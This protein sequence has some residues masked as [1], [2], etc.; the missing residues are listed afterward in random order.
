MRK[1]RVMTVVAMVCMF[2]LMLSGCNGIGGGMGGGGNA[3]APYD[4]TIDEV[5]TCGTYDGDVLVANLSVENKSKDYVPAS[6]IA[7]DITAT[8]DGEPLNSS[9]LSSMDEN[10]VNVEGN[11]EPGGSGKS[12]AVYAIGDKTEGEVVLT[13][14]TY[15]E[16][17]K[18][19]EFMK[20]TINL[21]DVEKRIEESDFAITID[22]VLKTDNEEHKDIVV[23]D[24]TFTNNS[25]EAT[26]Y[27]GALDFKVFQKG[28][29]LQRGYLPY[30]HPAYDEELD[31]NS[32]REI[33]GGSDL[34][35]RAVYEL[36]DPNAPIEVKAVDYWKN[37][38]E[39]VLE[40]EIKLEEGDGGDDSIVA[41]SV[42]TA[43]KFTFTVDDAIIGLSKY[44]ETPI[45][46]LAGTFTNNSD[47]AI[48]FSW[49]LGTKAV[50][51]GYT[52]P[53]AYLSGSNNFNYNEIEPG[54]TIPIFIGWEI[55]DSEGD[56]TLTVVDNEH[57]AKEEIYSKTFTI[58]ELMENTESYQ[59]T[60][61]VIDGSL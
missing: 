33:Q 46:V 59:E 36:N 48:S 35:V 17:G 20:E 28:T 34:A 56:I 55:A 61:E 15:G 30:K 11:I 51:E 26:S 2:A 13:G 25:S 3:K 14:V 38:A 1:Q 32:Y 53:E 57:Y 52:L 18:M 23:I 12:Q 44:D 27:G 50:Q 47:E 49:A 5:F 10:Y 24:M 39:P 4:V 60:D 43:S 22:N 9:Y 7:Y 29:E 31:N 8:I 6:M 19:V 37:N 42:D 41:G 58:D 21:A 16:N 54:V 45:V 40:K